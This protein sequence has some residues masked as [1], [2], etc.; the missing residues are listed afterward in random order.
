MKEDVGNAV[1]VGTGGSGWLIVEV[2]VT[3]Q[4]PMVVVIGGAGAGVEVLEGHVGAGA[5]GRE[6]VE[7][8]V[9]VQSPMVVLLGRAGSDVEFVVKI[10]VVVF[11]VRGSELVIDGPVPSGARGAGVVTFADEEGS[12]V[13]TGGDLGAPFPN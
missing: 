1:G 8:H 13:L 12:G 6:V 5:G 11:S 3:G 2:H 4:S 7:V 10:G 9:T